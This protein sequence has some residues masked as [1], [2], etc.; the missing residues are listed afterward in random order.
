[1]NQITVAKYLAIRLNE[2]RVG[3][4]FG[5]P[6]NHLGPCISEFSQ[7]GIRWVGGTN[8]MNIGYAADAY[9]RRHGFAVVGVTYGVGALSII[10]PI[11][12]A[13]VEG[14][15]ILVINAAPTYAQQ[16]SLRD[17]NLLT[18]H[19]SDKQTSNL[20]A[21]HAVTG[22]A[23]KINNARLAPAIIDA[24]ITACLTESK[25]VYLEINE[26]VFSELCASP[27]GELSAQGRQF[28]ITNAQEAAKATAAL[29]ND[30]VNYPKGPILWVG[31][32]IKNYAIQ[33]KVSQLITKYELPFCSSVMGKGVIAESSSFFKGVY[34]GASSQLPVSDFFDDEQRCRIGLG[35]WSTSKNVGG[36]RVMGADWVMSMKHSVTVGSQYFPN[37]G[38][39]DF[40]EQLDIELANNLAPLPAIVEAENQSSLAWK[41][42]EDRGFCYDNIF[43]RLNQWLWQSEQQ[44]D[45]ISVDAPGLAANLISD[46]G[47]S[48]IGSQNT[49]QPQPSRFYSQ[50]TWLSIGYSL[51]AVTGLQYAIKDTAVTTNATHPEFTLVCIGDG[52]FQET[53]QGLSDL[54]RSQT[55]A[56]VLIMNNDNFYGIEQMLVDAEYYAPGSDNPGDIYNHVQPWQYSKLIEV[57]QQGSGPVMIKGQ[58]ISSNAAFASLLDEFSASL[59]QNPEQPHTW[60]VQCILHQKDYPRGMQSKVDQAQQKRQ[61]HLI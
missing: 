11:S 3:T 48:L 53:A 29:I 52:S 20:D 12:G 51:G 49:Y 10:N 23:L 36:T 54:V 18:S 39:A 9:A 43:S 56:L 42:D 37:V 61:R 46:A 57:F 8:E 6:G 41:V 19:M 33:D 21:Y 7:H 24:A 44:P 34:S 45:T 1:M 4:F 60:L 13:Y 50:S 31:H 15:P 16:L 38:L 32:E 26:N 30:R 40:V 55:N 35:S 14:V 17:I 28:S 59:R 47:F 5:V 22:V 27:K 58:D 2:Q 25:P